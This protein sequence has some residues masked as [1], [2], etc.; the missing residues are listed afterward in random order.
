[1]CLCSCLTPM[2]WKSTFTAVSLIFTWSDQTGTPLSIDRQTHEALQQHIFKKTQ[3]PWKRIL[4]TQWFSQKQIQREKTMKKGSNIWPTS[5]CDILN[6]SQLPWLKQIC[7]TITPPEP[8]NTLTSHPSLWR[9][10]SETRK[11]YSSKISSCFIFTQT[12]TQSHRR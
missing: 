8:I 6:H 2:H 3:S 1:M 10:K 7:K 9:L 11:L 12:Q 4:T 5:S